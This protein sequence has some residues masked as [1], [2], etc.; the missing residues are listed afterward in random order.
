MPTALEAQSHNHV[1][2]GSDGKESTC[3]AG[4]L[5]LIFG[6]GRTRGQ[7]NDNPLQYSCLKNPYVQRN[8]AGYSPW[9]HKEFDMTERLSTAQLGKSQRECLDTKSRKNLQGQAEGSS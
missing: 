2:S 6:L 3:T 5:G 7:G 1:P 4:G 9:S 8:L